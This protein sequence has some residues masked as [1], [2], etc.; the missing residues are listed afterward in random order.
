MAEARRAVLERIYDETP[1]LTERILC[2]MMEQ[3][4]ILLDSLVRR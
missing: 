4:V 1:D 3:Q 2:E